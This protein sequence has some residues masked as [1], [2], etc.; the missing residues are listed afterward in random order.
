MTCEHSEGN[1]A[2]GNKPEELDFVFQG[3]ADEDL[4]L[5][6]AAIQSRGLTVLRRLDEIDGTDCDCVVPSNSLHD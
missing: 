1:P 3:L 6:D 5:E 4:T 2:A